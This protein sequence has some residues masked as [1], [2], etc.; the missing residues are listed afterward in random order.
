MTLQELAQLAAVVGG[1]GVIV[2]FV[3]VAIQI[4]NNTRAVHAATIQQLVTAFAGQ[5]DEL[6]RNGELCDIILR[7]G[8]DFEALDRVEKARFRFQ[9]LGH[10]RR[11][12]NA[13]LQHKLGMLKDQHWIGIRKGI[14]RVLEL[15]GAQ[16][17]WGLIKNRINPEFQGFIDK[18]VARSPTV[19]ASPTDAKPS[20]ASAEKLDVIFIKQN[21]DGP[22]AA[23][24]VA[25]KSPSTNLNRAG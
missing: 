11:V 1:I 12:E 25:S 4:R 15:P 19:A 24:E 6:A 22:E 5:A 8:D 16:T 17:A 18:I 2:S 14:T 7:G 9:L 21:G 20:V 10:M 13:Y 3:Y 23:S